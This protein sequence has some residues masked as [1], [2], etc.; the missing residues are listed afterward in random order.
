M[1][2]PRL[3]LVTGVNTISGDLFSM[4]GSGLSVNPALTVPLPSGTS[5]DTVEILLSKGGRVDFLFDG[6]GMFTLLP[7]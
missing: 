1:L 6:E 3:R 7:I 2:T 5:S 4:E